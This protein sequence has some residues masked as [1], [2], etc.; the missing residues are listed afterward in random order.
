MVGIY[1]RKI[2]RQSWDKQER[3]RAIDADN[4]NKLGWLKASETFGVPQE[5]L[6]RTARVMNKQVRATQK[7]IG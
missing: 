2:N 7:G 4:K 5:T 1:H 3:Q 6:W